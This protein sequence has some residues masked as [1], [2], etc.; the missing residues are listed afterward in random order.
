MVV[1]KA[2]P[3]AIVQKISSD[4]SRVLNDPVM[5]QKIIERGAVPDLRGPKEW[6]AFVNAELVKWADIARRANVKAD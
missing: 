4:V 1:P 5:Q 3:E 6:T 2:T